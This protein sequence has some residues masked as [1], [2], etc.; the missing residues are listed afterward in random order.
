MLQE[1]GTLIRRGPK[2]AARRYTGAHVLSSH[3]PEGEHAAMGGRKKH[4]ALP[5]LKIIAETLAKLIDDNFD[6]E[7]VRE[8]RDHE[9]LDGKKVS[10]DD[11]VTAELGSYYVGIGLY[12]DDRGYWGN[13]LDLTACYLFP[14]ARMFVRACDRMPRGNEVVFLRPPKE[15]QPRMTITSE[16][17][18]FNAVCVR[19]SEFVND[20]GDQCLLLDVIMGVKGH[21]AR[22]HEV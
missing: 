8:F 22:I 3:V 7:I 9:G 14:A 17:A 20:D 10:F 12:D 18:V 19:V 1:T 2:T 21:L 6:V 16:T 5:D 13:L 4:G 11:G 15:Y